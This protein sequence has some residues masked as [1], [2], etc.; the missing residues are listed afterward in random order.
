MQEARSHASVRSTSRDTN[1]CSRHAS[2]P[3]TLH[4]SYLVFFFVKVILTAHI[5][6]DPA[7]LATAFLRIK[8]RQD[9]SFSILS[10]P[11]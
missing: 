6:Q 2:I 8:V 5:V 9:N 4:R 7:A 10:L 1:T 3:Q 11:L